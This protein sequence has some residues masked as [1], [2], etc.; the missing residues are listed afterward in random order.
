MMNWSAEQELI[1]QWF[2]HGVGHLL[3]RARAGCGKTTIIMEG[4]SI[5]FDPNILICAFSKIIQLELDK[6]IRQIKR[7]GIN[8]RTLHSVGLACIHKFRT[9]IKISFD[10]TRADEITAAV[11]GI[12]V[13]SD[14]TRLVTKLHTKGR[15]IAPHAR[16]LGDLSDLL[17]QFDCMPDE[18]WA[19]SGFPA[20][21]V[22][23]LALQAMEYAAN[24]KDNS[25]IDGSDMIFLP[26]RNRWLSPTYDMVVVD[27]AQD[28]TPAQ[29]EIALGVLKPGGRMCIVGDDRQAIFG[30]RGAD[31][32]ALDRLKTEL[33]A[34]ELGLKTTYR[35]G[36]EIVDQA[37]NYVP[38]FMA[39]P[40]NPPGII[41][42][43]VQSELVGLAMPGDFILSRTNAPLVSTAMK[44]LRAG[45]RTKIA[46][47]DLDK[48]LLSI[49]R[50]TRAKTVSDFAVRIARWEEKKIA[51]LNKLFAAA[52]LR[53]KKQIEGK[54]SDTRDQAAVLLEI[55]E[56]AK[57]MAELE[58]RILTL[59]KD[60]GLGD[61][62][63]ITCSSV[64]RAKGLEAERV[65]VLE[66][67]LRSGD[68][69]EDNIAY[70]AITRAK[71]ELCYVGKD[72]HY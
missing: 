27:E 64:H 69:E 22:E 23:E 29:L 17:I 30:F 15:E 5:A 26:V 45:K 4:V 9:G 71:S 35:C 21:K 32:T 8:A 70:V 1:R 65:F 51:D 59:F 34:A 36:T 25:I 55:S 53:R 40:N 42:Q 18:N 60:D 66:Y 28:M 38:D 67:T 37:Q 43:A 72:Y 41:S 19:E 57:T 3:V 11:C 10:S 7:R 68:I 33:G 39:G 52:D 13:P 47:K 31:S 50:K 20:S 46:G 2:R 62:G 56:G 48:E 14:I 6:R 44:L 24:I 61:K 54:I 58:T 16:V 12:M 63:L 49:V